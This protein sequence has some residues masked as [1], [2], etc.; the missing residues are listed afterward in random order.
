MRRILFSCTTFY[1]NSSNT[2]FRCS[3]CFLYYYF[4]FLLVFCFIKSY[5]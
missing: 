4:L 2:S 3:C 5:L 1:R